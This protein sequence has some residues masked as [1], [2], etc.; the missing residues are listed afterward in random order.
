MLIKNDPSHSVRAS[1]GR[2]A[3]HTCDGVIMP[4]LT[5][6]ARAVARDHYLLSIA[7][8]A[9]DAAPGQFV[10][11][12]AG[13]NADPL[14]R[15]PFSI[16]DR[17][18]SV[19]E[20]VV[21][22][23]GRG[24]AWLSGCRAGADIDVLAPLGRGFTLAEDKRALIVGG[25]VGNAPLQYLARELRARACRVTYLYG[26]ASGEFVYCEDAF[27]AAS[28]DFLLTTDDGSAGRR[29]RITDA[30]AEVLA[31]RAFD[32]AYVCGP[33]PMMRAAAALLAPRDIAFELSVENYFGCGIG[34]CS[35]C[36]IGTT[37][38]LR[39][40]CVDGPVFDG[41]AIHWESLEAQ[42]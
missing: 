33:T 4:V 7:F 6:D 21:R 25:G 17:A 24:T 38:G 3:R 40:A 13:P 35:G 14:L 41:R 16:Y 31:Q 11:I 37:D 2:R 27:R 1:G 15:R 34:V 20:I 19:L 22:V 30:L 36:S 39:R 18:G 28:D 42:S 23:V 10:N 29:G 32:I 5:E 9:I 12:K 26:A 8:D